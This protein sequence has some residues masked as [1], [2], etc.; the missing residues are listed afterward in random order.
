M[1]IPPS[2]SSRSGLAGIGK[3]AGS[4]SSPFEQPALPKQRL[5]RVLPAARTFSTTIAAC[6]GDRRRHICLDGGGSQRA[7]GGCL[8]RGAR[9]RRRTAHLRRDRGG[10]ID[11]FCCPQLG[12]EVSRLIDGLGF[13][14]VAVSAASARR[15]AA[16]YETRGRGRHPAGFNFGHCFAYAVA[17]EYACRLLYVGDDFAKTDVQGVLWRSSEPRG[18]DSDERRAIPVLLRQDPGRFQCATAIAS[19][20]RSSQ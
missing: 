18:R 19:S 17:K 6:P 20:L 1:D 2:A 16:A 10:D 12:A 8:H 11:C 15:I 4:C 9:S 7:R 3:A 13:G 14:V 5:V